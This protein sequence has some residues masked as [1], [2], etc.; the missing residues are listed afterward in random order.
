MGSYKHSDDN[1]LDDKRWNHGFV[2]AIRRDADDPTKGDN[3]KQQRDRDEAER[4]SSD[5]AE[6]QHSDTGDE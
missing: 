4:L 2:E 1:K 3:T 5:E 6:G